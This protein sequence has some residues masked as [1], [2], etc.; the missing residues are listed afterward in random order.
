[1]AARSWITRIPH[2]LILLS[3]MIV[4]ATI[5]TQIVPAGSFERIAEGGRDI[6]IPGSYS[7]LD[8]SPVGFW[9]MFRAVPD[10]FAKALPVI[11]IC[12]ASAMLFAILERS[13]TIERAVGA[14]IYRLGTERAELILVLLTFIYGLL[15]VFVGYENNIAT[16]PI[17]CVVVLALG[18]DLVLAA[19]VAVGGMT[20][21]FGLSP[22][23]LY[24]VGVGHDLA[25]MTK[26]S[27]WEFRSLLCFG[28]LAIT[29]WFNLRY[30]RRLRAGKI[31]SLAKGLDDSGFHFDPDQ[32]QLSGKNWAMLLVFIGGLFMVIYGGLELSWSINDMS[33]LFLIVTALL[34]IIS[35]LSG[36]EIADA[37]M[38]G[39]AQIAPATFIIGLASTI[40][41]ILAQGQITD[42]ISNGMAELLTG[43]P[44]QVSAVG[45]SV[46]QGGF[47]MLIPSGSGQAYAT[48]PVMLPL[49]ESLGLSQQITILAFQIGDG[50]TNLFNPSLGGLIA[51]LSL[52]RVPFDRWFRFVLPLVGTLLVWAWL[53]LVISVLIGWT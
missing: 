49:G 30:Y 39:V 10:G 47:N 7:N 48:L 3:G 17:A 13:R 11:F 40:S 26:F 23:N 6:I 33:A 15:G 9:G 22:F 27:G 16:I 34:A 2:P 50:V 4:F 25:D 45:M 21:A 46:L 43:L 28:A 42:T 5:L 1:M 29:A 32:R 51:M 52:C 12:F 24:T 38:K 35:R 53:G 20:A 41:V 8:P 37:S 36:R 14:L 44:S 19:G 18:G 31:E